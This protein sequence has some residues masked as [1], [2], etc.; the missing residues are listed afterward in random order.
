MG[1]QP[2][3][4]LYVG[5]YIKD[6]RVLP[7]NVRG[8]WVDL[9]LFMW[10][11]PVRGEFIGTIEEV[12]RLIG[13]GVE[14][15]RFALDL[16]KQK[17]TADIDLLPS[18]EFKIVSRRMKRD[19]E[20]SK[21]RSNAGKNGV[22]AKKDKGFASAKGQAKHKQNTEYDNEYESDNGIKLKKESFSKIQ[23]FGSLFEDDMFIEQ[24]A[25]THKGK[26][27]KVAFEECYTHHS[28]A[29]NPPQEIWEWKQKLNTWLSI[30]KQ[31]NGKHP[32][33]GKQSTGDLKAA[34]ANR[35]VQDAREQRLRRN[36]ESSAPDD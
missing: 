5:D 27:L 23:I 6:T 13:C 18:G 1:R 24:L 15:A 12:A 14:E 32:K 2:Y 28:N 10:D 33:N 31:D 36:G 16:L 26:D 25:M 34:F 9:I 21:I 30:K 8:A 19:A 4:P 11:N 20:I 7:L 22:E 17:R 29:P 35:V 3:M